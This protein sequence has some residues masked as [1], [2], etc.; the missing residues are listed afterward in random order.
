MK[1][2]ITALLILATIAAVS[3]AHESI[4][5]G[6]NGGKLFALDSPATPNAEVLVKEG[7]FIVGLFDKSKK[8]IALETQA[9]TITAGERS[10]PKKLAVTKAAN[11]FTAPLPA[12]D[13]YWAIFQLKETPSKKPLTF[14]V[15]YQTKACPECQKPEWLCECGMKKSGANI[16]VPEALDGL[17]AEINQHQGELN[18][19]FKE[20]KYEPLDE[21]TKA[22]PVLL[23]A[24]PAKSADKSSAAQP[25]VDALI[26]DLAA[27]AD[28]NASRALSAAAK[29]LESFNA[30]IAALKKN[31]PEKTANARP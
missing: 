15:H 14:R 19:H 31:Y 24:L 30:G 3:L 8:P 11:S 23:K 12:G 4:T 13:D 21:V 26:A 17:F 22:F 18:E 6:P 1:T 5:F 16:S 20:K 29:N 28:A 10:A 2:S 27:I 25:Q 9:L 7:Q